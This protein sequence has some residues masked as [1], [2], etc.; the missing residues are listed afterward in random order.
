MSDMLF[1]T[2]ADTETVRGTVQKIRFQEN[3]RVIAEIGL[4]T[5]SLQDREGKRRPFKMSVLGSMNECN[6]GQLYE[7]SGRIEWNDKYKIHQIKFD[8]YRTI[9]PSDSAGIMTYL[10]DVACWC[11]PSTAKKLVDAFG[12][13]TLQVLREEPDRVR[14]LS[15]PGLTSERI[16]EMQKSLQD[17]ELLEAATVEVNNLL[18][19]VLGPAT[20]RKAIKK[21]RCDAASMIKANPYILTELHGVGFLSADQVHTRLGGDPQDLRR[22]MAAICHVL[23]EAADKDGH[24]ILSRQ[25]CEMDAGRLVGKLRP[26]VWAECASTSLIGLETDSVT[27]AEIGGSERYIAGKL[28]SMLR[29]EPVYTVTIPADGLAADQVAAVSAFEPASVFLLVGAPGTGKTYTVARIV[30]ALQAAGLSVLLAAPT[31][32]AAKQMTLALAATCGGTACTIHSLLEPTVDEESGEFAFARNESNPLEADVI[33]LDEMS[34]VDA[35]LMRSFLRA[36]RET[37][38]LLLVGDHYQLPSVGPGAV[39]R[40]LLAAGVPHF[41]LKEIKRNAGTIVRACH[42]IKDGKMPAPDSK[43]DLAAGCNWR[44]IECDEPEMI[45]DTVRRIVETQMPKWGVDRL[46]GVQ[47]VS[48]VNDKGPL[49]CDAINE[50]LRDLLNPAAEKVEKLPFTVGDKVL[51]YQR[52]A[53]VKGRMLREEEEDSVRKPQTVVI[54]GNEYTIDSPDIGPDGEVRIVNGDIGIVE[55]IDQKTVTVHLRYPDRIV[56]LKRTEHHLKLAYCMTCH[57]LQGSECEV[58][59]LPLHRSLAKMPMVGRE[60]IYTGLSRAKRILITVGDL[61]ALRPMIAK[62]GTNQRQTALRSLLEQMLR[63]QLEVEL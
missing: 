5:E 48:P 45:R 19:G 12:S 50:V 61:D 63:P 39:L 38:R 1:A 21:W 24:T 30:S 2:A 51:R 27:L 59:I 49:S 9:L 31:G 40:D 22:H 28:A 4:A 36:V 34:M 37:T 11:G 58:V 14:A 53:T 13:E 62:V 7:F 10:I 47:A 60:W 55:D 26:D 43:L 56:H 42:A 17:N 46:W 20:V 25:K 23:G 32:K 3:G 54:G 16:D 15:L 18:A 57:K 8:S 6:V 29:A 52:N 33:V 35:R 44:H 41:E